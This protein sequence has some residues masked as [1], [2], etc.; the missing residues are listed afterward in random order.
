MSRRSRPPR[1]L[2]AVALVASLVAV[3][4]MAASTTLLVAGAQGGRDPGASTQRAAERARLV[5]RVARDVQRAPI[6]RAGRCTKPAPIVGVGRACRTGD[7]LLLLPRPGGSV[8]THGPDL[9]AATR[10]LV[11]AGGFGTQASTLCSAPG[12][13]RHVLLAYLVPIDHSAGTPDVHGDR[14]AEIAPQLRQALYDAAAVMDRRAG[15]LVPGARRRLRVACEPDGTPT[16]ERIVL[17]RTAAAYRTDR[18]GGFGGIDADLGE[19]GWLPEYR[20][21]VRRLVPSVRR[22]LAYYD[23]EFHPGIA[24]QGVMFR[25]STMLAQG[26]APNDPLVGRTARNINNNPP[27]ASFA[28]QYG[29]S[30]G[31]VPEPPLYTSLLH[32]LLH[33]MGAVQDDVPTSSGAGHCNDGIDVMCY[34]DGGARSDYV[35]TACPAATAPVTPEDEQL[36]CNAD[37]YFHPAPPT[38]NPLAGAVAWSAGLA[39]NQVLATT[40]SAPPAAVGALTATGR[41]T[42]VVLAWRASRGASGHDI[43]WRPVGG[44]WQHAEVVGAATTFAPAVPPRTDVE[45]AVAAFNAN[46]IVGLASTTARRTGIDTTPP[47]RPG[48]FVALDARSTSARLRLVPATDND[49]VVRYRVERLDGRRWRVLGGFAAPSSTESP[50]SGPRFAFLGTR[51]TSGVGIRLRLRAVDARGNV[52][53]PGPSILVFPA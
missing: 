51:A 41:G 53:P 14:Y 4:A 21:H 32:E 12:S 19:L 50:V 11:R 2:R 29:T 9:A 46:R 42:S 43:A 44:S 26:A 30:V 8:T 15:E 36:D 39:A 6:A 16:V 10:P 38:G 37:T 48:S 3:G 31:G 49:R 27:R 25:R 45:F 35:D 7:G 33:T 5:A 47:G 22:V 13:T 1:R 52:S 24:G 40:S 34:D 20:D 18:D 28:L 23:A 17:P